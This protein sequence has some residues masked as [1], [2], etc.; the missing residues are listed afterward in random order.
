MAVLSI[1]NIIRIGGLVA[2]LYR[3]SMT[4]IQEPVIES[5]NG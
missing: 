3:Q 2:L 4:F 1:N 5:A